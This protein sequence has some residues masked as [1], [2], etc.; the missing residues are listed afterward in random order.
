M[1]AKSTPAVPRPMPR[2]FTLPSAMPTTHTKAN[3]ADGVRD[4]L[5]LVE[6]EEP[7]HPIISTAVH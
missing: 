2:N 5:R 7:V 3:H 6:L 4:G 1:P